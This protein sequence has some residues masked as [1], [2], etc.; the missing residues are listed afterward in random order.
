MADTKEKWWKKN[1]NLWALGLFLLALVLRLAYIFTLANYQLLWDIQA[2]PDSSYYYTWAQQIAAGQLSPGK[3][4]FIG[5]LYAYFL[6]IVYLP[7][8]AS[9]WA[10][11]L[12]Q[13]VMGAIIVLLLYRTGEKLGGR[14]VGIIA[15]LLAAFYGPMV[16]FD[17]AFVPV[18]LVNLLLA[19]SLYLLC[20][21]DEL[22]WRGWLAAGLLMGFAAVDRGNLILVIPLLFLLT[23]LLYPHIE[24]PKKRWLGA[25]IF[26]GGIIL[27]LMPTTIHNLAVEGD[28]VPTTS[29][30]GLNFYIGNS[31][32]AQGAYYTPAGMKGIPEE[33]NQRDSALPAERALGRRLKPSEVSNFWFNQ[34]MKFISGDFGKIPQ[35]YWQKYVLAFTYLELP[36]NESYYFFV[37]NVLIFPW[38]PA[39]GL[40]PVNFG[41]LLPL[42]LPGLVFL[43][44]GK[45]GRILVAFFI[46]YLLSMLPFFINAR[47]RAPQAIPLFIAAATTLVWLYQRI[48]SLLIA[49]AAK[50]AGRTKSWVGL[51][52]TVVVILGSAWIINENPTMLFGVPEPSK[53]E[54][55][56][57]YE[58]MYYRMGSICY[59]R[60]IH[61]TAVAYYAL[62]LHEDPAL[63][64]ALEGMGLALSKTEK[65]A[66]ALASAG[67]ILDWA[68]DAKKAFDYG[69]YL[70]DEGFKD[71]SKQYW[72]YAA[73][74]L[75]YELLLR[76]ANVRPLEPKSF[77]NLGIAATKLKHY[78]DADKAL[79]HAIDL[80]PGYKSAYLSKIA[81]LLLKGDLEGTAEAARVGLSHF[82][83]DPGMAMA[84]AQ[85]RLEQGRYAD[86]EELMR[87]CLKS[88]P[89]IL[90]GHFTLGEAYRLQGKFDLAFSE[91]REEQKRHSE[92]GWY[93]LGLSRLYGM[94]DR[95]QDAIQAYTD[96]WA[97]GGREPYEGRN[98]Y[99][100][101]HLKEANT[102]Q[103]S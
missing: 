79:S 10:G 23:K 67:S 61:T 32:Q 83:G 89:N 84:W 75:T 95:K 24:K 94:L 52:T 90:G 69:N 11:R 58:R 20:R 43:W 54:T 96:Y 68:P 29:Q 35:L 3:V 88:D 97:K 16:Y 49:P 21:A 1:E 12:V 5:P 103:P 56:M 60:G 87:K 64:D 86:A 77:Y 17:G 6:A 71:E 85:A 81:N 66:E 99:A 73:D 91:Y 9:L 59:E 8:G 2:T 41:I 25:A 63:V 19:W 38:L 100:M 37:D 57:G 4:F 31:P 53:A 13:V 46:L 45:K 34:G 50:D 27:A 33:L 42:A 15:G 102:E 101:P 72:R 48:N 30:G 80:D 65:P 14:V 92:A 55:R 74:L 78:D 39:L 70:S 18:T 44:R 22:K 76:A 26:V 28:L 7:F 51:G 98:F 47:Y 36:L 82:P 40:A 93:I 62:A